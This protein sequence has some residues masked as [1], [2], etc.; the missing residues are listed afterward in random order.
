M[1]REELFEILAKMDVNALAW[2]LAGIIEKAGLSDEKR[3]AWFAN[4]RDNSRHSRKLKRDLKV[5]AD[6]GDQ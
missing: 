6:Q 3:E 5:K 1:D 4:I 2:E